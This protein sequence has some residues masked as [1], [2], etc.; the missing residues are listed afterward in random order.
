[1]LRQARSRETAVVAASGVHAHAQAIHLS[2]LREVVVGAINLC[3]HKS[4]E[5]LSNSQPT[6]R[7]ETTTTMA[8]E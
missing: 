4:V 2:A 3:V 5:L 6:T 7:T 8:A 1:M